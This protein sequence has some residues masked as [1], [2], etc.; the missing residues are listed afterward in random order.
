MKTCNQ[1]GK[2][3]TQYS[4]GGLSANQQEIELWDLFNPDI[5]RYVKD[6]KIWMDPV[7]G[8]Q[9]ALCPWLRREEGGTKYTCDIYYDRPEDC[10]HYP[11]TIEQMIKDDCE[12][13]ELID[14]E[15]PDKAQADL[16]KLM[17]DS[18]PPA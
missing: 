3:C 1:C 11:V 4:N 14:L 12:M 6:G 13:L 8:L 2:C 5:A 18:R 16:N 7:T 17:K 10:R 15:E 9:L